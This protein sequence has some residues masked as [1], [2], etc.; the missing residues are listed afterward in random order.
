MWQG[1]HTVNVLDQTFWEQG[2]WREV[3]AV[4]SSQL[5]IY[6]PQPWATKCP[7]DS[8][9][10]EPSNES[11][12]QKGSSWHCLKSENSWSCRKHAEVTT[13]S[14]NTETQTEDKVT[15]WDCVVYL[16]VLC[17]W[18]QLSEDNSLNHSPHY[19]FLFW[20]LFNSLQNV[21]SHG[22][23]IW[24]QSGLFPHCSLYYPDGLMS[25]VSTFMGTAS[26]SLPCK[27]HC[28]ATEVVPTRFDLTRP[29]T[30]HWY[31]AVVSLLICNTEYTA[32]GWGLTL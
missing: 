28:C 25:L 26:A 24:Y 11:W 7:K 13:A 22:L 29:L 27:G 32:L 2:R 17:Q 31:L 6:Q 15:F 1:T 19:S 18:C 21:L 12:S 9:K 30:C 16:F 3:D 10:L 8:R 20:F 14:C 5:T 23:L 4:D